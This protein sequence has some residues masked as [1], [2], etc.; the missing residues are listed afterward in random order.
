MAL[1]HVLTGPSKLIVRTGSGTK[2]EELY[3]KYLIFISKISSHG[4]Y[5]ILLTSHRTN[6]YFAL[7]TNTDVS[8]SNFIKLYKGMSTDTEMLILCWFWG[9]GVLECGGGV[10]FGVCFFS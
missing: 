8:C 1:C 6:S 5:S 2:S 4:D 10:V 9:G 7:T 3:F